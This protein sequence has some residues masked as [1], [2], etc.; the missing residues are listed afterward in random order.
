MAETSWDIGLGMK[1][2]D[3]RRSAGVT[4]NTLAAQTGIDITT[5]NRIEHVRTRATVQT[6]VRLFEALHMNPGE[7]YP[8]VDGLLPNYS[9]QA[10]TIL[11]LKQVITAQ[12]VQTF[13]RFFREQPYSA[14][15][16][17]ASLLNTIADWRSKVDEWR[18]IPPPVRPEQ[19][20]VLLSPSPLFYVD[21]RYPPDMLP[22]TLL[23][24]YRHGGVLTQ[25]DLEAC[26]RRLEG[27]INQNL[28][29]H[30]RKV[31]RRLVDGPVGRVKFADVMTLDQLL[32]SEGAVVATF[33]MAYMVSDESLHE[34]PEEQG[35]AIQR[36]EDT[37]QD[38]RA[39]A[40]FIKVCRWL[41]LCYF[42]NVPW[43]PEL[44]ETIGVTEA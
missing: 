1:L 39:A 12:D 41:Q 28:S 13:V 15:E 44:R 8:D 18:V 20:D 32:K 9:W 33:W 43:L 34:H 31:M 14:C 35:T 29:E 37:N 27:D 3:T 7:F 4:L 5:I 16:V 42:E 23:A 6:A 17:L 19:I 24:L 38:T 10:E 25:T 26:I 22:Q 30:W 11:E 40:F 36:V 21:L 2:A